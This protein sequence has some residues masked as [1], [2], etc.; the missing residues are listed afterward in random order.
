M[1]TL[2]S[3]C[4]VIV[5]EPRAGLLTKAG[6]GAANGVAKVAPLRPFRLTV[7]NTGE[8]PHYLHKG[9]VLAHAQPPAILIAEPPVT[10]CEVLGIND[11]RKEPQGPDLP[12][13]ANDLPPFSGEPAPKAGNPT[14]YDGTRPRSTRVARTT[15]SHSG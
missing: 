5:V 9:T 15:E 4:G 12:K 2:C 13:T 7:V 3:R 1:Q 10:V 14:C 11:I 6:I 8:K